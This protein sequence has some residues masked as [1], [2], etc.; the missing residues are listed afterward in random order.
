M[1]QVPYTNVGLKVRTTTSSVVFKIKNYGLIP[2]V[3]KIAHVAQK[4]LK[5]KEMKQD[6]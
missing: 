1:F 6:V 2:I 4:C 5:I 3:I